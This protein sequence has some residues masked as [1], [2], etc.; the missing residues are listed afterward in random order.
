MIAAAA[1][2]EVQAPVAVVGIDGEHSVAPRQQAEMA[3]RQSVMKS[4]HGG[5]VQAVASSDTG[6]GLHRVPIQQRREQTVL[7]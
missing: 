2:A 3:Q 5:T 7:A 1:A 6:K 4:N